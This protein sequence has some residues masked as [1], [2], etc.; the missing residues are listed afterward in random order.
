VTLDGLNEASGRN[1]AEDPRVPAGIGFADEES[2]AILQTASRARAARAEW[3]HWLFV[4]GDRGISCSLDARADGTYVATFVPLWSPEDQIAE[5]FLRPADAVRWQE[6]M[7]ERLHAAGWCLVEAG[8]V[9]H[10]A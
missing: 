6:N 8:I 10:A 7:T 3:L 9:T 4:H 1:S 2:M 5:I